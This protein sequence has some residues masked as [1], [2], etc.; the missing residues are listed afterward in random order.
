MFRILKK[1]LKTG[2]VTGSYPKSAT[3]PPIASPEPPRPAEI[4]EA[5]ENLMRG[6]KAG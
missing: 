3:V 5:L 1:S 4:L 2:V 6:E